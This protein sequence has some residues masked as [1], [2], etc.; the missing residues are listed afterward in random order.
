MSNKSLREAEIDTETTVYSTLVVNA[1]AGHSRRPRIRL[2][3]EGKGHVI[4]RYSTCA[5]ECYKSGRRGHS[6]VVS[7]RCKI[8]NVYCDMQPDHVAISRTSSETQPDVIA[9]L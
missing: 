5:R 4:Y 2:D 1:A 8:L 3:V 6:M 9:V 7:D